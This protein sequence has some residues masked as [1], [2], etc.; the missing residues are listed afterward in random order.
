MAQE[1]T[2]HYELMVAKVVQRDWGD[3]ATELDARIAAS[4]LRK[5]LQDADPST[6][7]FFEIQELEHREDN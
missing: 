1:P 2:K 7:Y 6:E 4:K 3:F 5:I